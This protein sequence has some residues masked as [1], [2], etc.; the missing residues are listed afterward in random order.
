MFFYISITLSFILI[1][2]LMYFWG[3]T[4]GVKQA[5]KIA[6]SKKR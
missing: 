1:C 5:G 4:D 6:D 3:R 2:Q